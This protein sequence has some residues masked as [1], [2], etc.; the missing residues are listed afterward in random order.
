MIFLLFCI[1][2][3]FLLQAPILIKNRY[4]RDLAVFCGLLTFAAVLIFLYLLE[5][6]IPSPFIILWHLVRDIL[7]ISYPVR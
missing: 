6:S 4:W 3:I 5:V 2:V 7:G 1:P